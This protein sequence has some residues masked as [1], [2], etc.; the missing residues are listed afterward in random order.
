MAKSKRAQAEEESF[1]DSF[2][3]PTEERTQPAVTT[4]DDPLAS[5][6]I[7]SSPPANDT[8]STSPAVSEPSQQVVAEPLKTDVPAQA[9]DQPANT[10]RGVGRRRDP[11]Y[12]QASA[13]VPRKLRRQVERALLN[14]PGE[15]D[16]SELIE[17][18]LVKW[19]TDQGMSA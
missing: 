19:L 1:Y 11:D 15:R 16:Y 2:L 4:G 6:P 17:E 10:G 14:D 9:V 3:T 18:L 7:T 5:A 8:P 12:M 13:Y